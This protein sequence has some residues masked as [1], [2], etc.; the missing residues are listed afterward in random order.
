MSKR[1]VAKMVDN[2]YQKRRTNDRVML[3]GVLSGKLAE[4]VDYP[5]KYPRCSNLY[6]TSC[7][8]A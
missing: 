8:A 3:C 7:T 4:G 1:Q 2:L 6:W 5:K